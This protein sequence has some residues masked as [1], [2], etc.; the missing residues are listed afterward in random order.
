MKVSKNFYS[1]EFLPKRLHKL[2]PGLVFR[3]MD[4]RILRSIQDIRNCFPKDS[5]VVNDWH[6][7]GGIQYRGYRPFQYY[8]LKCKTNLM[9]DDPILS[10]HHN[11]RALDFVTTK[12]P[13][14]EVR[15]FIIDN[16]DRLFPLIT[17]I[18]IDVNWIHIDCRYRPDGKLLLF[19]PN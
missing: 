12:T 14:N 3:L 2:N 11:G 6:Y 15:Q 18:E 19:K 17:A 16:R 9:Q 10:Q 7:E 4:E 8:T 1:E 13:I 5:F